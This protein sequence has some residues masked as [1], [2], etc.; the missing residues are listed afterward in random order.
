LQG[1]FNESRP[2]ESRY[3]SRARYKSLLKGLF[4]QGPPAAQPA[5]ETPLG[6]ANLQRSE[7]LGIEYINNTQNK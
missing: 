7:K 3:E 2:F 6:V 1:A 4:F 5:L